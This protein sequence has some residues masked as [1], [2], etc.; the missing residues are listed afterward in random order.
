MISGFFYREDQAID[1]RLENELC[2]SFIAKPFDLD[3]VRLAA[4]E[5]VAKARDEA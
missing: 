5:A 1:E 4:K 3:E 2:V